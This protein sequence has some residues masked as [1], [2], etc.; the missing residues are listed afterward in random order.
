MTLLINR[1]VLQ[2]PFLTPPSYLK[3][4]LISFLSFPLQLFLQTFSLSFSLFQSTP[5]LLF[6]PFQFLVFP[7]PFLFFPAPFPPH[8][9]PFPSSLSFFTVHSISSLFFPALPSVISLST[10]TYLTLPLPSSFYHS[11]FHLPFPFFPIIFPFSLP[12]FSYPHFT[13]SFSI[14][15]SHSIFCPHFL[16][17]LLSS[18]PIRSPICIFFPFLLLSSFYHSITCPPLTIPFLILSPILVFFTSLFFPL[19]PLFSPPPHHPSRIFSP[20]TVLS[21]VSGQF[22]YHFV[23]SSVF[24]N[25]WS[26]SQT[27]PLI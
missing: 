19:F 18:F 13:I 14:L 10:L 20:S 2:Y 8:L 23:H 22:L 7:L 21:L 1:C 5:P 24:R 25:P 9:L 6:I 17:L 4:L 11:C 15:F 26:T 27:D 16:I 12:S 3:I